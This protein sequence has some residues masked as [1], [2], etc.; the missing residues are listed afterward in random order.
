MELT[1]QF[2]LENPVST[3][4]SSE[5]DGKAKRRY[6]GRFAA[7][8]DCSLLFFSIF[9]IDISLH[10]TLKGSMPDLDELKEGYYR[11]IRVRLFSVA[12]TLPVFWFFTSGLIDLFA[13]SDTYNHSSVMYHHGSGAHPG[14]QAPEEYTFLSQIGR[15]KDTVYTSML[16]ILEIRLDEQQLYLHSRDSATKIYKI[17]TGTPRLDKGIATRKGVFLVQNKIDWLYSVQ[18]DSTK[19]F[20]WLGFNWGVGFHSLLGWRYYNYLGKRPS[21]HGCVRLSREDAKEIYRKVVVGTP[22]FVHA[23]D[24]ARVVT[25]LPDSSIIDTT[26]YAVEEVRSLYAARLRDLYEGN[27]LTRSYSTIVLDRKYIGHDGI[28]AGSIDLV[29][30]RQKVPPVSAAFYKCSPVETRTAAPKIKRWVAPE[31][32]IEKEKVEQTILP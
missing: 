23:G 21:S 4:I 30:A 10:V 11:R 26:H 1:A 14:G 31:S 8:Q 6:T 27:R 25:F 2:R 13:G 19:V 5:I 7:V 17:S 18:F 28:P 20:N 3:I 29:P 22:V 15:M 24:A 16:H 12:L 9:Y 32:S